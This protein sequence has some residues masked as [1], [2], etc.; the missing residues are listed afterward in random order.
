MS[1]KLSEEKY[2]ELKKLA[3]Q[4]HKKL[5]VEN[6][7]T[8]E[9][10]EVI[11]NHVNSKKFD[12]DEMREIFIANFLI[13]DDQK[14][15]QTYMSNGKSIK[16]SAEVLNVPEKV[17]FT[18]VFE[19]GKYSSYISL[20]HKKGEEK[21]KEIEI[22]DGFNLATGEKEENIVDDS[23]MQAIAKINMLI[24]GNDSKDKTIEN[25]ITT[26]SKLNEEIENL[27]YV[28]NEQN[29]QINALLIEKSNLENKNKELEAIILSKENEIE[30]MKLEKATLMKYKENYEKIIGF[31]AKNENKGQKK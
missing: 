4:E 27:H 8:A 24:E 14:F 17:V 22:I 30:K 13:P 3:A 25:Q 23:A 1:I 15:Y 18:R 19:L 28:N 20:K 26:I 6:M 29:D 16:K 5:N 2:K 21:M 7:T 10:E 12:N 11:Q 31:L 9:K